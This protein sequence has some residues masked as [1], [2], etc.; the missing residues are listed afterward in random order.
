MKKPSQNITDVRFLSFGHIRLFWNVGSEP[1][2]F[3][4]VDSKIKE[5]FGS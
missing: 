2:Y 5:H 4:I 3:R 1:A